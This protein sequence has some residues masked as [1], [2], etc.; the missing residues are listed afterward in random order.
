ML[1]LPA[2]A[3]GAAAQPPVA[4]IYHTFI[5]MFLIIVIF[6]FLLIRPQKKRQEEHQGMID[7]LKKGD[8]VITAGGIHAQVADVRDDHF[9]LKIA[10]NVRVKATKTS[11]S[12]KV[13]LKPADMVDSL[14]RQGK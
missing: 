6:Y 2:F 5:M 8:D 13:E 12:Q 10:D 3:D 9:I 7:S 14:A 4:P 1:I 11:I